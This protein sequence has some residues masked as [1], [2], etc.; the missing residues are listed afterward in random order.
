MAL[1][2][3]ARA[4]LAKTAGAPS[5]E[6]ST[7]YDAR[8]TFL[9]FTD[10][11]GEPT[12]MPVEHL[13]VPGPTADL[14]ARLYRPS[15]DGP[16]PAIV[17]LHGS[18]FVIGNLDVYDVFLRAL[19]EA[20]GHVVLAV[21]YQKAPE[22]PFPIPLDDCYETTSWFHERAAELGVDPDR[23]GVAGDSAGGT[24]AAAVAVRAREHGPRLAFQVLVHPPMD[25]DFTTPS[26][27]DHATGYGLSRDGMRW[28]WSHYLGDREPCG[29]AA[30]LRADLHDLP[31][32][33]VALAEHDPV[34]T[35]GERYADKLA[36]A[37]VP[38]HV[39][40]FDGAIHGFVLMD[41]VMDEPHILLDELATW[42][43]EL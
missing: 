35:D 20:T 4:V 37:G 13:F 29:L 6:E 26:Y 22:H 28:F 43:G 3:Q 14:P 31:P 33:F 24:L 12:P 18:G 27:V 23:I 5:A 16:L 41:A 36:A 8:Q 17:F 25:T 7:V 21:N 19:A 38:V 42:L 10:F 9:G 32:A 40:R 15:G 11:Q 34:R 2:D 30:P 1:N 39:R